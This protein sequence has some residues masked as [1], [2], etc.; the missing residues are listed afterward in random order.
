MRTKSKQD[1]HYSDMAGDQEND[2][3]N[4]Y[5]LGTIVEQ[6]K[7]RWYGHFLK[8]DEKMGSEA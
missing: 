8:K 2:N 7:L 5:S 1:K 3:S 6:S 4:S